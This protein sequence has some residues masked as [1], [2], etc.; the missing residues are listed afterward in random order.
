GPGVWT[1]VSGAACVSSRAEPLGPLTLPPS[2]GGREGTASL[3]L[4]GKYGGDVKATEAAPALLPLPSRERVGV[5]VHRG[6]AFPP[7][8]D[9]FPSGGEGN[10]VELVFALFPIRADPRRHGIIDVI[11]PGFEATPPD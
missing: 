5:R 2:Q 7:H 10:G 3:A 1:R 8:P 11:M 4:I 9:L 6:A